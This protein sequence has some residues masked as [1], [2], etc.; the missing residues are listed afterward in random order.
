MI[1]TDVHPEIQAVLRQVAEAG[2]PFIQE[3]IPEAAR[4]Q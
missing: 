2:L 3:R 1:P 4:A